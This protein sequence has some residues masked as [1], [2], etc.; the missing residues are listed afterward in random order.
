MPQPEGKRPPSKVTIDSRLVTIGAYGFFSSALT[1]FWKI[2]KDIYDSLEVRADGSYK[3]GFTGIMLHI[4]GPW[5]QVPGKVRYPWP[6]KGDRFD[7]TEDNEEYYTAFDTLLEAFEY[8]GLDLAIN[9]D[10][11]YFTSRAKSQWI[12]KTRAKMHPYSIVDGKGGNNVGVN[13]VDDNG[14]FI[15]DSVV[16]P[17]GDFQ[18]LGW[19]IINERENKFNFHLI[20]EFGK[21]RARWIGRVLDAI[22]AK[23]KAS[24]LLYGPKGNPM[25]QTPG[26]PT[27]RILIRRANEE[28]AVVDDAT[29]NT[30]HALSLGD[31]SEIY[32]WLYGEMVKRD[33]K[34]NF[35][36]LFTT[37]NRDVIGDRIEDVYRHTT[38][39]NADCQ[40][41]FGHD[42]G[43][44]ALHE[45]HID[46]LQQIKDFITHSQI[47]INGTW[48]SN[49]GCDKKVAKTFIELSHEIW[50]AAYLFGD[51]IFEE[52]GIPGKPNI[53]GD[54]VKV[55]F[56]HD[57]MRNWSAVFPFH[58]AMVK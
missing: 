18:W 49:D 55:G 33:L 6:L 12:K 56:P 53:W 52:G 13:L 19:D 32:A 15:Y 41:P 47:R 27:W 28:Q 35:K 44:G 10:D 20:G 34:P 16:L 45:I 37:V 30:S 21:A 40:K 26:K 7:M 5:C 9:F 17:K 25:L 42:F 43:M 31:R 39:I 58:K 51:Y 29:G 48:P 8:Y 38:V 24:R 50:L 46:S 14:K 11:Q 57:T 2:A 1:D 54:N 3:S 4:N 22:A 36:N 23:R